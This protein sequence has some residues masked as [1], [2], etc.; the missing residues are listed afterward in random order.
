MSQQRPL[1]LA[2]LL[3]PALGGCGLKDKIDGATSPTVVEGVY[4]GVSQPDAGSGIDLSST[5]FARGARIE[6]FLANATSASAL[7]EAPIEG[8]AVDLSSSGN[9]TVSLREEAGGHY[10]AGGDDGLVYGV[11]AVSLDIE[12]DDS[13]ASLSAEAPEAVDLSIA[14]SHSSLAPLTLD[15][16]GQG[17]SSL[18]VVVFDAT[19]FELTYS[20]EPDDIQSFYEFGH[21]DGA[22]A[23]EL[24]GSA[25]PDE[26]LYAVAVAG[27]TAVDGE[28]M[29]EMNTLLSSFLA[30]K[31]RFFPVSTV[32]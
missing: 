32:P 25:F 26:S 3:F 10:L 22:E 12:L 28:Q 30:G 15:A 31:W 18:M 16:S 23:V 11:E 27:L 2:A 19:T 20:N 5:D 14:D 24:P 8:A 4:L 21:G 6:L 13:V 29:D 1:F 7:S 9:G 17:F